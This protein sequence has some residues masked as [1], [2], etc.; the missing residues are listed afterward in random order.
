VSQQSAQQPDWADELAKQIAVDLA[1]VFATPQARDLVAARLRKVHLEGQRVGLDEARAAV[2][3]AITLH[4]DSHP[5][6][7]L[8]VVDGCGNA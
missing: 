1:A 2:L 5:R 8:T 4:N 7:R 3:D 6:E